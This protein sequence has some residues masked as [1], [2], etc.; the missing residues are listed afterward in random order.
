M[1]SMQELYWK[2]VAPAPDPGLTISR[3]H[4]HHHAQR[5]HA[6]R[7][8]ALERDGHRCRKCGR[9]GR[10]LAPRGGV[11]DKDGIADT[12]GARYRWMVVAGCSEVGARRS[13]TAVVLRYCGLAD[14]LRRCNGLVSVQPRVRGWGVVSK[15]WFA[16]CI[17]FSPCRNTTSTEKPTIP[18][19][20]R[21]LRR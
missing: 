18:A 5:W 13:E 16:A 7:R 1:R 9:A 15:V 3:C 8:K 12:T 11:Y 19:V 10:H 17:V 4:L 21:Y 14:W 2:N 6:V 20:E